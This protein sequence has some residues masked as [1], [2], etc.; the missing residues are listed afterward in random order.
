MV[1]QESSDWERGQL[2]SPF[3]LSVLTVP[4]VVMRL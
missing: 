2:V 1:E 4:A 3:P